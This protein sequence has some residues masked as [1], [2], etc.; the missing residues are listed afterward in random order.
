[1][2]TICFDTHQPKHAACLT[3]SPQASLQNT[4]RTR[5]KGYTDTPVAPDLGPRAVAAQPSQGRGP[6]QVACNPRGVMERKWVWLLVGHRFGTGLTV[7]QRGFP[8]GKENNPGRN[9][10]RIG[11]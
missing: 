1:M 10:R 11:P 7:V 8:V 3:P 4:T 9:A 5:F 6:G 2:S